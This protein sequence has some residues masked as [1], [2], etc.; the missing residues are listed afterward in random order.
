[1]E[2]PKT[3]GAGPED[4]L[5]LARLLYGHMNNIE[6]Y[7]EALLEG[8]FLA[9]HYHDLIHTC[10]QA[11]DLMSRAPEGQQRAELIRA[12]RVVLR[13]RLDRDLTVADIRLMLTALRDGFSESI[14]PAKAARPKSADG[15]LQL[16]R[17]EAAT[18]ATVPVVFDPV[19]ASLLGHVRAI[20]RLIEL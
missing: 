20:R 19:P 5:K 14:R 18:G 7:C 13:E 3:M 1:M 17:E 9:T 15:S 4:A 11:A 2:F 10:E 12:M 6:R 16:H 8:P